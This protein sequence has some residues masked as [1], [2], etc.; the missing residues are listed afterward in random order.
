MI[1]RYQN[2]LLKLT[3]FGSDLGQ[4]Q[5]HIIYNFIADLHKPEVINIDLY[6]QCVL[7]ADK[8]SVVE[9]EG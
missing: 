2:T 1:H 8:I 5:L 9:N 4:W 3:I 7:K 6:H